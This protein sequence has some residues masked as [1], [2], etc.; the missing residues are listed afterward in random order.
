MKNPRHYSLF[1]G[2]ILLVIFVAMVLFEFHGSSIPYWSEYIYDKESDDG[3]LLWGRPR[4]VR[5]DEWLVLTPFMLSQVQNDFPVENP[6][7]G[8]GK[9]PLLMN[10]PARHFSSIFKPHLAGFFFLS[11]ERAF[12]FYWNWKILGLLATTFLVLMILTQGKIALSIIGSLWLFLST[13][14][15]WWFSIPMIETLIA[16]NFIF[17]GLYLAFFSRNIFKIILGTLLFGYFSL[18][19]AF[20][21]LYPPFQITLMYLF[22]L[23]FGGYLW[24]HRRSSL[25]VY[26]VKTK[27]AFSLISLFLI[28]IVGFLFYM[29]LKETVEIMMNTSYPGQRVTEGGA[30]GLE[31][32]F[33]GFFD[34]FF[35]QRKYPAQ[36]ENVCEASNFILL[37]PLLFLFYGKKGWQTLKKN[38]L[39]VA[40]FGYIVLFSAW[41]LFS[42]PS[43]F[44]SLSLLRFVPPNRAFLGVGV[45]NIFLMIT[46]LSQHEKP[47]FEDRKFF[48]KSLGVIV[49]FFILLA[50][51]F[52]HQT[53]QL[54]S[55]G[56]IFLAIFCMIVVCAFLMKGK[57]LLGLGL[58]LMFLSPN[59]LVNPG[60]RGLDAMY[61]PSFSQN[62][63]EYHRKNPQ[64][65]WLVFD[66]DGGLSNYM[67]SFGLDVVNGVQYLPNL[68]FMKHID[69]DRRYLDKYNRYS[70][71]SFQVPSS[72][73]DDMS[74]E[75]LSN[76]RTEVT[77]APDSEKLEDTDITHMMFFNPLSEEY[78][79]SFSSDYVLL[80]LNPTEMVWIYEREQ[81]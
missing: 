20:T 66:G 13:F 47:W 2:L 17:I 4:S 15:Q 41:T 6:S 43:I 21:V 27:A 19:F 42:L 12:S 78:K 14:I 56:Y 80:Y 16:A 51:Y 72:A 55:I 54:L 49:L 70:N 1:F 65:R 60:V 74:I 61:R 9:T 79:D 81:K 44:A 22:A 36:F 50:G 30:G 37:F 63:M 69:P 24:C 32:Y 64:A 58:L 35:R 40:L 48:K 71:I 57:P 18:S 23:L 73:D 5:S 76:D 46:F 31:R 29:D 68:E 62:I 10:L 52:H 67:K 25:L 3:N 28:G 45:A 11:P 38:P 53:E 75:L 77:I 7:L 26:R 34:V 8:G 39:I 33:A 59:I